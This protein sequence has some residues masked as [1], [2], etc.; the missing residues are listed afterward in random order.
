MSALGQ[1]QKCETN[2]RF[3]PESGHGSAH[4]NGEFSVKLARQ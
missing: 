1:K 3:T 4:A 2:V